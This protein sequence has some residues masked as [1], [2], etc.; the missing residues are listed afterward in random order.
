[1]SGTPF[2]NIRPRSNYIAV[3]DPQ[4]QARLERSQIARDQIVDRRILNIDFSPRESRLVTFRDPWSF[5]ILFHP[6]C[7]RLIQPHLDGLARKVS[8]MLGR[9]MNQTIYCDADRL[10]VCF[11]R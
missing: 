2:Q 4:Q 6:A 3:L 8:D 9:F 5:P 1:M 10:A 11:L 7:D